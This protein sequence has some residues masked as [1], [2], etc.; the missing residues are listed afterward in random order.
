MYTYMSE[1]FSGTLDATGPHAV[2]ISICV[3]GGIAVG[4]GIIL[5]AEKFWSVPTMLVVFG[6]AFEAICTILL[7]GFDEGISS[8]QQN[9]IEGER[10]EIISLQQSNKKLTAQG[11]VLTER[12][13]QLGKD[14]AVA[15]QKAAEAQLAL[16]KL[17]APRTLTPK[18]Q[19][20]MVDAL[21]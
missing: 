13:A 7:F 20:L 2:L 4:L 12:A 6:V 21:Q 10:T 18:E 14:A 9:I 11:Q 3:A 5:E 15:S 17:K 1:F 8:A 19:E 16:E